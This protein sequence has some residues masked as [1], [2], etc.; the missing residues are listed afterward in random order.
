MRLLVLAVLALVSGFA[1]AEVQYTL[2]VDP[3]GGAIRVSVK[4]TDAGTAPVFRIPAWCP[5]YY[6]ILNYQSK[7]SD[8]R[9][10]GADGVSLEFVK[11]D[12]RAW[13]VAN[14][15]GG[16]VTLSYRVLGD[17][18]GLGFF[19]V[20]VKPFT[21][22]INGPAAFMYI[23]GKK[24]EPTR[25]RVNLPTGWEIASGMD[26][27]SANVLTAGD[28]DELLDHPIQLG[29]FV[30][31]TF[32]HGTAS[33]EVV[34][35]TTD[36]NIACNP[37][38]VTAML[39][40][41][42]QPSVKMWGETPFKRYV[43]LIHLAVGTFGGGLEHRASTVL[44]IP[45][46][47]TLNIQD[48]ASHEF[49]HTWLVKNIR[50]LELGPFDYT[51]EVRSPHLWLMEGTTDYYATRHVYQSGLGDEA[52]HW[53]ALSGT[54]ATYQRGKTRLTKT[55]E[56]AGKEAWEG[57]SVGIGDLSY[58]NNGKLA[59]F[60]LDAAI[61]GASKGKGSL[62]DVMRDLYQKHKL[63]KPGYAYN[64]VRDAVNRWAGKDISAIH[65]QIV[66]ST[67]EVPYEVLKGIGLRVIAP[68]ATVSDLGFATDQGSVSSVSQ[69][70][71]QMGLK[72][73]DRVLIV[74]SNP[75]GPGAFEGIGRQV[76]VLGVIRG[77][78]VERIVLRPITR[79][80]SAWTVEPDPFRSAE[81]D[82]RLQ[83]LMAR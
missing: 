21:A 78:K 69:E 13:R 37:D 24:E 30:R 63:P 47:P 81:A 5:G 50:P 82:A 53:S 45:N 77:G 73:G 28:Y 83:E 65:D 44:A 42:I 52:Y 35:V 12:P 70:V 2:S 32:T 57:G 22:F 39:K 7:I 61:R 20:S 49:V 6:V 58:Y 33:Y 1:R 14:P 67:N 56:D 17:D 19:G 71:A 74:N 59:G 10:T 4:A 38:E 43:F 34:F 51:Q 40:R 25:L 66:R 27:A 68:G 80:V 46:S 16:P 31:K 55:L 41:V 9:A 26:F 36:G 79:T 72:V 60:L 15:S 48:L 29:R 23:D 8:V 75:F 18:Q 11:P 3:A 76:Y 62:D 54:I 64:D